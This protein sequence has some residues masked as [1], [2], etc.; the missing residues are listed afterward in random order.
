MGI[1]LGSM[2]RTSPYTH[3]WEKA[4]ADGIA[5]NRKQRESER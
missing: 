3:Y 1:W 4:I 2:L 5:Y